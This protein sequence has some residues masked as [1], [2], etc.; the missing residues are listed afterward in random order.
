M[1]RISLRSGQIRFQLT[2]YRS[3]CGTMWQCWRTCRWRSPQM[4][5]QLCPRNWSR[6]SMPV[7]NAGVVDNSENSRSSQPYPAGGWLGR[8]SGK[9]GRARVMVRFQTPRLIVKAGRWWK[10][11]KDRG[12]NEFIYY[13]I[14]YS[15]HQKVLSYA[16]LGN[17]KSFLAC[18]ILNQSLRCKIIKC[19]IL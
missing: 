7:M 6:E 4:T 2:V 13:L 8:G 12:L 17:K 5:Q 19:T 18:S 14:L 16:I 9:W 11:R 3:A 10:E 1:S 15:R